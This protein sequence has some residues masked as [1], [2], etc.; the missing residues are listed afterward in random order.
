MRGK[1]GSV[2]ERRVSTAGRAHLAELEI[3][4][5]GDDG[6][7]VADVGE[8][9]AHRRVVRPPELRGQGT[10]S[11]SA[12]GGKGG[13]A[14]QCR[15]DAPPLPVELVL[16]VAAVEVPHVACD[17]VRPRAVSTQVVDLGAEPGRKL[18]FGC[19]QGRW[20]WVFV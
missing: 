5:R 16:R 1:R 8:H 11:A 15:E 2:A 12:R 6:E 4:E 9:R 14:H 20:R 19:V 13:A 3:Y 10:A 7:P 18:V 17:L